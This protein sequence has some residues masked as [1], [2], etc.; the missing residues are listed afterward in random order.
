MHRS[1]GN[2]ATGH[3][4]IETETPVEDTSSSQLPD[5]HPMPLPD[6]PLPDKQPPD[7]QD[8]EPDQPYSEL[9]ERCYTLVSDPYG[10][11]DIAEYGEF[12]VIES[13][14]AMEDNALD[15][16]GYTIQDLSGDGI[17]EL[18]VGTLPEYGGQINAVYTLVDGQPQ[19]VF[20]GW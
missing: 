8:P 11:V 2:R 6:K 18:V 4:G 12:G 13:A 3:S 9:V 5:G 1:I 16:L 20:E 19:F 10:F 7:A 14:R 17:P 15:G